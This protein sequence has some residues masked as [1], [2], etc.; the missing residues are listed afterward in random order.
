MHFLWAVVGL[1]WVWGCTGRGHREERPVPEDVVQA[2]IMMQERLFASHYQA[3][4]VVSRKPDGSSTHLGEGILWG[5]VAHYVVPCDRVFEMDTELMGL[6]ERYSGG[7]VRYEPLGEYD[8][9]REITWDGAVG[10]YLAVA[11]SVTRCDGAG[12]WASAF[13]M[14]MQYLTENGGELYRGSGAVIP[15]GFDTVR[16]LIASSL[17]LRNGPTDDGKAALEAAIVGVVGSLAVRPDEPCY[18]ANLA[19]LSMMT[20]RMYGVEPS[21]AG[22][23]AICEA[24]REFDMPTW[25]HYCGRRHMK[26][27]LA[28]WKENEWEFRFQR[29][30]SREKPDGQGYVT[31]GLDWLLG[32]IIAYGR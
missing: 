31:P 28:G 1:V 13:A 19:Y 11:D 10:F 5:G 24:S 29:C 12:R 20:A 22:R 14:H 15:P 30:G 26:D 32:K 23:E 18:L 17:G 27:W 9:G 7:L 3:P 6:V 8:G 21:A 25:D 2:D 16:V 4:F